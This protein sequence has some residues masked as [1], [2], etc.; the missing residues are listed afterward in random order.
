MRLT[1]GI[2]GASGSIYGIRLLEFLQSRKDI[3]THLVIS[4]IAE[5]VIL[6][7]TDYTDIEQVTRL[8]DHCYEDDDLTAPIS[9]GSFLTD[10][11]IVVPCSAKT[12]SAVAHSY[13]ENLVA[14]ASDVCLKERRK[15]VLVFRETPLTLSHIENM[16]NVTSMGGIILPPIPGFY[17]KP[18]TIDDLINHTVGKVLDLFRIEHSLFKRWGN[19]ITKST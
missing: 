1:I 17:S 13:G 11:M 15:F 12:L 3:E 5:S 19:S 16:K 4:K 6:Y 14:R 7:E 8:A 18:Q 9:S 10:G 2:T